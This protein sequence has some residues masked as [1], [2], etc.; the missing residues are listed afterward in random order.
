V[1]HD[2]LAE[3]PGENPVAIYDD[4]LKVLSLFSAIGPAGVSA[5]KAT[6]Y[7]TD[8][9][10]NTYDDAL[11]RLKVIYDHKE[12]AHFSLQRLISAKQDAGEDGLNYR[13]RIE[14]YSRCAYRD[15]PIA[16]APIPGS[17]DAINAYARK[18]LVNQRE[19]DRSRLAIVVAV[20]GLELPDTR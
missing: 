13:L 7:D 10:M 8:D 19:D 1:G 3:I 12:T 11:R 20:N 14:Q 16:Y 5:L 9:P 2:V 4:Q 15:P 18:L 17:T 6:G